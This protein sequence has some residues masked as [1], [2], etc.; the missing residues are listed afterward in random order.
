MTMIGRAVKRVEDHR[1]ITGRGLY[2]DDVTVPGVLHVAIVRST[3]AH[4]LIRGIDR[5]DAAAAPGVIAVITAADLGPA[6]GPHP[7]PTW[8]PPHPPLQAA[9]TPMTRPEQIWLLAA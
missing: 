2:V 3:Y 7:H 5:A 4:A 9:V 6:N 1:F 8:F